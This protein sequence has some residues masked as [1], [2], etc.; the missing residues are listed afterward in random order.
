MAD[1]N[2]KIDDMSNEWGESLCRD[3]GIDYDDL[4]NLGKQNNAG[5]LLLRKEISN[6]FKN[7]FHLSAIASCGSDAQ[8]IALTQ[9]TEGDF[10][11]CMLACGSCVSSVSNGL[12]NW[13]TTAGII[14]HGH[15]HILHPN[16][17][18][19]ELARKQTVALPYHIPGVLTN[20]QLKKYENRCLDELHVRCLLAKANNSPFKTMLMELV[21]SGCGATL[22]DAALIKIAQLSEHHGFSI[23][24]NEILTSGRTGN[25]LMV[26]DSGQMGVSRTCVDEPKRAH[27]ITCNELPRFGN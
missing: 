16:L 14:E 27:A 2:E 10:H 8:L 13:S 1:E 24:L 5:F 23:T 18:L 9:A 3:S 7:E 12:K 19:S 17:A 20:D 6:T 25:M 22:G 21:L 26:C 15:A 4:K 11:S